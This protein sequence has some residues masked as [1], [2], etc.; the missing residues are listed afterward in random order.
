MGDY[1]EIKWVVVVIDNSGLNYIFLRMV[2]L[3]NND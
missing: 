2:W 3:Y 1:I